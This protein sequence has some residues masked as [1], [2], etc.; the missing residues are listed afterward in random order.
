MAVK[1]SKKTKRKYKGRKKKQTNY[2]AQALFA[3]L[4]LTIVSIAAL[5]LI[6][7]PS[8]EKEDVRF[9]LDDLE[10]EV[11]S[12]L[13][14][15]GYALEQIEIR[16][17]SDLLNYEIRGG[18]PDEPVLDRFTHR[19]QKKFSGIEDD[20]RPDSGELLI[21]RNGALACLLQFEIGETPLSPPDIRPGKPQVVIIMDDLGRS[22]TRAK[23]LINLGL[24][25][26]FSILPGEQLAT[27]VAL[28]A[29]RSGYEVMIHLPME[30]HS[31]P[32][33]NPGPEAL[34]LGQSESEMIRKVHSYFSKVPYAAGANNHMGSRFTEFDRG[35]K[36]VLNVLRE[37]GM[38]FI[39]SRTTGQSVALSVAGELGV[40]NAVRDVFLDNVAEVDP[41][42]QQIRKL[43]KLALKRGSAIGICHPYPETIEA[44]RQEVKFLRS[45]EVDVVF[46]SKLVSS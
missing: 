5:L 38:F 8:I 3:G 15:S 27:D 31:Y 30:P 29:A 24:P 9:A 26:T 44:L 13:L 14:R 4:V 25:V 10:V 1:N 40:P 17:E 16:R 11:E 19:L 39:D 6:R 23:E 2:S 28:L 20:R 46:A 35:M 41:I 36:T 43:I 33:T 34:L 12:V 21:Y 22:L 32:E 37:K 7:G 45:G 18:M 42:R